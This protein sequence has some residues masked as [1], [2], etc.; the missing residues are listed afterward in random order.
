[1]GEERCPVQEAGQGLS[2]ERDFQH[3]Q[4]LGRTFSIVSGS[5]LEPLCNPSGPWFN[6]I[7]LNPVQGTP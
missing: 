7:I 2:A 3:S 6:F 4:Q 1:M 5:L